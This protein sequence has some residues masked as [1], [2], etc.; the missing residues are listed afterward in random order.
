MVDKGIAKPICPEIL[1]GLSTPRNPAEIVGG[2]GFDVLENRAKI[3]DSQGNDVTKEY[4]NGAM[5]ALDTCQK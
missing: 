4:I 3:I 5:K 1:G 2:D